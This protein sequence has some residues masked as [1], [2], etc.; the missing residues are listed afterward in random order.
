MRNIDDLKVLVLSQSWLAY[1]SS[2][3]VMTNN[4]VLCSYYP[5]C[6]KLNTKARNEPT[7]QP[8]AIVVATDWATKRNMSAVNDQYVQQISSHVDMVGNI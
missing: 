3:A 6:T 4:L 5:R 1:A 7:S 2:Q 8:I